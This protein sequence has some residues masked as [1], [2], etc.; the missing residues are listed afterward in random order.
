M[1]RVRVIKVQADKVADS[2]AAT[3]TEPTPDPVDVPETPVVKTPDPKPEVTKQTVAKKPGKNTDGI[4]ITRKALMR[5]IVGALI[6]LLLVI[7]IAN[8]ETADT[9]NVGEQKSGQTE[10]QKY[11]AELSKLVD[12]PL[13]KTPT[14]STVDDAPKLAA[15]SPTLFKNAQNGDVFLVYINEDKSGKVVLYRP[16]T[17]KIILFVDGVD[18]GQQST[19]TNR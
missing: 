10:A 12:L 3:N 13:G 16:S 14:F 7:A 9:P 17:K 18:L 4:V 5:I 15:K 8:R 19:T 11:E 1:P 2:P 6:L